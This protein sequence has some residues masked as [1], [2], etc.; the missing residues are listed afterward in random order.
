MRGSSTVH[1]WSTGISLEKRRSRIIAS[2]TCVGAGLQPPLFR[3]TSVRSDVEGAGDLRP[4]GLVAGE[5]GRRPVA[6]PARASASAVPA[7]ARNTGRRRGGEP[8][9]PETGEWSA[10][11]AA[12]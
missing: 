3:L 11:A 4:V 9:A 5:L 12:A 7:S 6:G 1:M 8:T 10:R 2:S